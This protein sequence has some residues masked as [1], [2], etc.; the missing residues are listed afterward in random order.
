MSWKRGERRISG[1]ELSASASL[2]EG[3]KEG[4]Y[5]ICK[6]ACQGDLGQR[7]TVGVG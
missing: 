5:W 2:S 4:V 7:R 1:R 3:G 6:H